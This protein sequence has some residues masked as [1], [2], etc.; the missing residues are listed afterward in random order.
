MPIVL[1]QEGGKIEATFRTLENNALWVILGI[2]FLALAVAYVLVKGVLKHPEGTPKMIEIA[3]AIQEGASAYLNRQFRTLGIFLGILVVFLFFVLPVP[4]DAGALRVRAAVRPLDRVH[5]RRRFQRAH[6]VHRHVAGG[7]RE[8]ARRRTPPASRASDAHSPSRSAPAASPGCSPSGSAC[9]A[10]RSCSSS[11]RPTRRRSWS[12]SGSA[13]RCSRCSCGSAA[14]SSPKRPTSAPTSSARSR[15]TSPRTIPATRRRSP[16]TSA[17]TSAT[18]P[19]WRPT[20]SS[21]T[22]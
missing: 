1:A 18:A 7:A 8:R 12:G 11:T 14:A 22:R 16:T 2:S 5:H 9:S 13:G 17:T 4:K 15:R 20:S 6:R 10:R 3:K 19:V 21:P